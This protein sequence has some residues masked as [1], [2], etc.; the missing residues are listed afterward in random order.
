MVIKNSND[1]LVVNKEI[2]NLRFKKF[3]AWQVDHDFDK[4]MYSLILKHR[5]I[6]YKEKYYHNGEDPKANNKLMFIINYVTYNFSPIKLT[7]LR[8]VIH[9]YIWEYNDYYFQ[10]IYDTNTIIR[11]YNKDDLK[12]LLEI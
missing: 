4:L 10:K 9:N 12:L 7:K 3:E 5:N 2:L 8:G 1:S 6:E 11:I